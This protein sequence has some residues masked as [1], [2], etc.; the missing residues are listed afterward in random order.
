MGGGAG[1][2]SSISV[3]LPPPPPPPPPPLANA[4]SNRTYPAGHAASTETPSGAAMA[5]PPAGPWRPRRHFEHG[6]PALVSKARPHRHP[7][8]HRDGRDS[9]Q[10]LEQKINPK[11]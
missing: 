7:R 9:K 1:K 4:M 2:L 5:R 3:W 8:S 6:C 10:A 11:P